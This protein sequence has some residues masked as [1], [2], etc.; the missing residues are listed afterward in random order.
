MEVLFLLS[1]LR[2]AGLSSPRIVT[3]LL[4]SI[5]VLI[6]NKVLSV[7]ESLINLVLLFSAQ[8]FKLF[9]ITHILYS[10]SRQY[11]NEIVQLLDLAK[12]FMVCVFGFN[13]GTFSSYNFFVENKI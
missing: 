4:D 6:N 5:V 1:A 11:I 12:K 2:L 9:Y 10:E 3:E 13:K 7:I 8:Y